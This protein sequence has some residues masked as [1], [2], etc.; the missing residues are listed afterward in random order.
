MAFDVF[1]SYPHQDKATA[2]AA[3][4][5]LEAAGIRCWIAPRDVAPGADWAA[6][7][8]DA[9]DHCRAMVLIFSSSANGSRQIQR[10]VQHAFEQ[11]VPVIP[12]RIEN[13]APASSDATAKS[14]RCSSTLQLGGIIADRLGRAFCIALMSAT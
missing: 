14:H 6:S 4:A 12:L 5:S 7:I 9:I 3:C 1:I 10:E 8:V 13:V 11:E 2:D